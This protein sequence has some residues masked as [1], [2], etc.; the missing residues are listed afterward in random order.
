LQQR[1]RD[2]P[3]VINDAVEELVRAHGVVITARRVIR[4]CE[5]HG[6][7]MKTGDLIALPAAT[8]SRDPD[9]YA[10]PHL[11]DFD[12][13]NTRNLSFAAGPHRCIGSHLARREIKIA[14]EEWIARAP[15]LRLD[16]QRPS[17]A[18]GSV[19]V[20]LETLPLRWDRV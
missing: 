15:N 11:I 14:I 3:G 5:F 16:P 7:Q 20:G 2:D 1:L 12:R 17:V 8:A 9:E 13:E 19:V 18:H 4:D 6:V 10:E